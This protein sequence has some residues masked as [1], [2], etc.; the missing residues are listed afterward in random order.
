MRAIKR[1]M[2][3]QAQ[4]AK[5][6]RQYC[7]SIG[8]KARAR[9]D[10]F[11]MGDSVTVDVEDQPPEVM[12]KIREHLGQYQYG[13]FNGM[14]DI[15]E[16]TNNRNDIPQTKYLS[17]NCHFSHELEQAAYSFLVNKYTANCAGFPEDFKEGQR[18]RMCE[19]A[20]HYMDMGCEV[21][22]LLSGSDYGLDKQNS[23]EFWTEY[24][25]SQVKSATVHQIASC[26]VSQDSGVNVE[27]REGTRPGYSEILFSSKPDEETRA[28]LKAAG[29][30]WSRQN[31]V[32]WGKTENLPTFE[33]ISP[34]DEPTPP[35]GGKPK[36]NNGDKFKAMADKMQSSIDDKFAPRQENTAKRMAQAAHA[37]LEGERLKRTQAVLYA[38]ADMHQS[39][40]VPAVISDIGSKKA[41]YDLMAQHLISVSNGFHG[42]HAGS[43][44]M[45]DSL[46]DNQ[47]AIFLWSLLSPKSDE[48][49]RA[50]EL[51]QMERDLK[52]SRIPGYFPTPDKLIDLMLDY[53]G[54]TEYSRVLE[55]S[56]GNGAICD[57]VSAEL[58]EDGILHCFE[59]NSSLRAILEA[60]GHTLLG[61]DFI[62]HEPVPE[63]DRVLMNPPFENLQDCDHVQHAFKFLADGGR[64]ISIMSPSFAFNS[65]KKAQAF[66]EWIDSL[67]AEVHDIESGAFKES[68]TMIASKLVII[69]K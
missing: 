16:Y 27:I 34:D 65:S 24:K 54:L 52:G 2:S 29:F 58:S 6:A 50:D 62:D 63:Y 25:K 8:V 68:G 17:I 55:P 18:L 46:K 14:E 23:D 9:S 38:L 48:E 5:I 21:H 66:R 22:K 7:K 59:V 15:Y 11:S 35:T 13:S 61:G 43:G 3:N 32:W 69:D 1:E 12:A 28:S 10:S 20:P 47:Q 39:G 26:H 42:Y 37:R 31:G 67:G 40:D 19:N 44:D 49:K 33:G 36:K 41:V 56:A 57:R 51:K 53:A 64:L 45:H 60:K 30:R 4:V